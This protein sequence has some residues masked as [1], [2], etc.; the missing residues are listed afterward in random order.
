MD[1]PHPYTDAGGLPALGREVRSFIVMLALLQA[2]MLHLASKGS[3]SGWWPFSALGGK[4]YWY[5]LVLTVPTVMMLSVR[6]LGDTRFWQQSLGL[7]LGCAL[8]AAWAARTATAEVPVQASSVLGPFG[9]TLAIAGLILTPFLQVRLD[10]GRWRAPY[11]PLFEHAWQNALA[12]ALAGALVCLGWMLLTLWG[13]LFK[14]IG[15]RFFAELF[16][17][18]PFVYLATGLLFGLGL[19]IGRTQQRPVQMARSVLFALFKGLLPVLSLVVLMFVASLPFT[20]LEP[21][22]Q[23]DGGV[24]RGYSVAMVLATILAFQVLFLNAVYQDGE[25]PP[26]YPRWLRLMVEASL[27][28]MPVL[29]LLAMHAA[30]IRLGQY[31]WTADRFWAMAAVSVLFLYSL[32][33]SVAA[34]WRR[35]RWLARL[36]QANIAMALVIVALVVVGN[37]PLLDPHRLSAASQGKRLQAM[38][39]GEVAMRDLEWLR[40]EAGRHGVAALQRMRQTAVEEGPLATGIDRLLAQRTRSPHWPGHA[41]EPVETLLAHLA[42]PSNAQAPVPEDFLDHLR[43][44]ALENHACRRRIRDCLVLAIDGDFDGTDEQLLCMLDPPSQ[45]LCTLHARTDAGW[46]QVALLHWHGEAQS[47]ALAR[48]LRSGAL[49]VKPNAWGVLVPGEGTP[50]TIDVP[51]HLIETLP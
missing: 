4:V 33:Y 29:G 12:L 43:D 15:I 27:V 7:L 16:M 22:W 10:Q 39:A 3:E 46:T 18:R 41:Q 13:E 51:D 38:P 9:A 31:G 34:L 24:W 19:M 37:S 42:Q 25:A 44:G 30:W 11:R 45:V 14:L 21:L 1:H 28:A 50:R 36:P 17:E 47:Q 8:L 49:E 23:R 35:G 5:T 20:G 6:R 26:P 40:F 48:S 2:L 32:G